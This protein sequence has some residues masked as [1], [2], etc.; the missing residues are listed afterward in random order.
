[1]FTRIAATTAEADVSIAD[2]GDHQRA[3]IY[4]LRGCELGNVINTSAGDVDAV[5][6]TAV[7]VPGGTT[8]QPNCLI[9]VV[10]GH[11]TTSGNQVSGYANASLTNTAEKVDGGAATGTGGGWSIWTGTKATAGVYS[12]TTATLATSSRQARISIAFQGSQQTP[13][14]PVDPYMQDVT[15]VELLDLDPMNVG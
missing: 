1:V 12:A 15:W 9:F 10:I 11:A 13:N 3:Q 7:T 2:S 5:G 8:T 14:Q 6:S 4:V